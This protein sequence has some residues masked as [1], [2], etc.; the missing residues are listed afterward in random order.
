M[1]G[2]IMKILL[3]EDDSSLSTTL[4]TALTQ[5]AHVVDCVDNGL[6]AY[7]IL[8]TERY[9][10]V[11][12]DLSLPKM[13]GSEVLKKVR[14]L[15]NQTP[16]IILTARLE[17]ESRVDALNGGA[18]DYLIKPFSIDELLARLGAISRRNKVQ[19][20]STIII[21]NFSFDSNARRIFIDDEAVKVPK[22]ELALLE[23]L[24]ERQGKVVSKELILS[25]LYSWDE[26]P[27]IKV[28]DL[29][30]HRLRKRIKSAKKINICTLKGLGFL[31]DVEN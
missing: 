9:D 23:C 7:A 27:D 16:I 15:N 25:Q 14:E 17:I 3:V 19:S 26:E 18:D 21:D 11:I 5:K 20:K 31:L 29:Y 10:A 4:K 8:K 1:I 22:R 6:D 13:D 30:I 24:L 2:L 12:L 28:V